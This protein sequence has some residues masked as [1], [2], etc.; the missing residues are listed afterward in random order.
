MR[1]NDSSTPKNAPQNTNEHTCDYLRYVSLPICLRWS[2]VWFWGVIIIGKHLWWTLFMPT[3]L[4]KSDSKTDV[5]LWILQNLPEQLLFKT[6]AS[7]CFFFFFWLREH[8]WCNQVLPYPCGIKDMVETY[9]NHIL[10]KH[11]I[12]LFWNVFGRRQRGPIRSVLL[13]IIGWLVT[14]FSQKRL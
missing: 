13:V 11:V 2:I 1:K 8:L 9:L 7:R 12:F 14:R 5:F 10:L 6:S 4:L 3:T